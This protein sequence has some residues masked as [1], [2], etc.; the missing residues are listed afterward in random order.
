MEQSGLADMVRGQGSAVTIQTANF[1]N[2]TDADLVAQKVM[3]AW[4][5]RS[6]A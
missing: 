5:A 4:R 6:V 2:G 3:A 1:V